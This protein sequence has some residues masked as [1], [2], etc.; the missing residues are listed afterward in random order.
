[1]PAEDPPFFRP[2]YISTVFPKKQA[3]FC[4]SSDYSSAGPESDTGAHVQPEGQQAEG[5]IAHISHRGKGRHLRKAQVGVEL[6][7]GLAQQDREQCHAEK[8][9]QANDQRPVPVIEPVN[10][11][12][13]ASL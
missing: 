9:K 11:V 7:P 3:L 12:G 5:P 2:I 1:M 13:P 6:G 10:R 4:D 8:R